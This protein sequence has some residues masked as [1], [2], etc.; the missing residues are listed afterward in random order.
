MFTMDKYKFFE[1][2]DGK[3]IAVSTYAG[4][5]VKGVAKCDSR[6]VFSSEK[7]RE[8]AAARCALKVARKRLMRAE[9]KCVEAY[10][11]SLAADKYLDDMSDYRNSAEAAFIASRDYLE[12][13][14]E[15]M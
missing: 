9:N 1:T 5:T 13:L 10:R 15:E 12:E 2:K 11:Q 7:G 3:V 4:R 14:L 6:D 8:L